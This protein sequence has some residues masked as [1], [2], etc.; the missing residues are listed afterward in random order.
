MATYNFSA[1]G[2]DFGNYAGDTLK[3]A[4]EAFSSD[5]GY[6]SWDAMTRQAIENSGDGDIEIRE[7]LDNGRY[8]PDIAPDQT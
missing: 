1:N 8:G 3:N 5:A 2:T 4:C 7:I 6:A